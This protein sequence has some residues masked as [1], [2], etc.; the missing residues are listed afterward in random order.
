MNRREF[1]LFGTE[2]G[3]QV[4]ELSCEK[5]FMQYQDLTAG[6]QQSAAAAGNA[7]DADWWADE[8]PLAITR[9]D[10]EQFF[11]SILT[12]LGDVEKLT[13]RDLEWLGQRGD[14]KDRVEVLLTAFEARG[15]EI[16]L[17]QGVTGD[18]ANAEASTQQS[19][20]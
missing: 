15:G 4:A 2:G 7:D 20:K 1:L 8:P 18:D 9:A 10:P 12:E 17:G 3:N 19:N 5:L 11:L 16:R 6:F 14:F 13:V